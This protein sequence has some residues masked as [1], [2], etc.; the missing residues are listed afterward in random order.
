MNS[1]GECA[2]LL[3]GTMKLEELLKLLKLS[4]EFIKELARKL[5]F[6]LKTVISAQKYF[7]LYCYRNSAST[8]PWEDVCIACLFVA[9]KVNDT[10]KKIRFLL[11]AAFLLR[12]PE[13][14]G[15]EFDQ[16]STIESFRKQIIAYERLVLEAIDFSFDTE[17][18]FESLVRFAKYFDIAQGHELQQAWDFIAKAYSTPLCAKYANEVIA[19]YA[20]YLNFPWMRR[21]FEPFSA[22]YLQLPG[23]IWKQVQAD[24]ISYQLE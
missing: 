1:L 24:S 12:A 21:D 10:C 23:T 5:N 19:L 22:S 3:P 20:L 8:Y 6:P 7:V 16:E 11:L 13:F 14:E 9:S 4:S 18:T 2:S 17:R 15:K